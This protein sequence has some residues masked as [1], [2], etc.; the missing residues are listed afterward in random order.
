MSLIEHL[1]FPP[2]FCFDVFAMVELEGLYNHKTSPTSPGRF[3]IKV[4]RFS[5]LPSQTFY[6]TAI[7][8]SRNFGAEKH[9]V[10]DAH[11]HID[12]K[13]SERICASVMLSMVAL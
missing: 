9:T 12:I 2:S 4:I 6:S 3:Q 5:L 11:T 10:I 8:R 1:N 13:S 7:E